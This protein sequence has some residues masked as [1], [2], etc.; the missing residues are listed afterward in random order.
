MTDEQRAAL[1][2]K[3]LQYIF[4]GD[5]IEVVMADFPVIIRGREGSCYLARVESG[6]NIFKIVR[7][8]IKDLQ[9]ERNRV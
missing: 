8:A 3:V 5:A 2:A 9:D 4:V 7:T 1:V 6:T